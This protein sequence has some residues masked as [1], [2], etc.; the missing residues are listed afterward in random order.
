MGS[1]QHKEKKYIVSPVKVCRK[2]RQQ[3]ELGKFGD[4]KAGLRGWSQGV[5]TKAFGGC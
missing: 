5:L 4:W 3:E 2:R 1:D